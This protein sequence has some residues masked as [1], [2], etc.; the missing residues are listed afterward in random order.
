MTTIVY[1]NRVGTLLKE[2]LDRQNGLLG[3]P[4]FDP[5]T[6]F[7]EVTT[8]SLEEIFGTIQGKSGK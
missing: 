8:C 4:P 5:D 2:A 6:L 3:E 7:S 1:D